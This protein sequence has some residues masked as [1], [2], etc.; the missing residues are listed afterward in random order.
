MP[1]IAS[2]CGGFVL[3]FL[4][5][6]FSVFSEYRITQINLSFSTEDQE[7]ASFKEFINFISICILYLVEF[8]CIS[9]IH[10]NG[11]Y[12]QMSEEDMRSSRTGDIYKPPCT[13]WESNLSP[14]EEQQ[15]LLRA[16]L[17]L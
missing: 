4:K 5:S 7:G 9:L 12:P 16:K 13:G 3:Q 8:Y 6:E 15:V 17:S 1:K 11:W 14:L 10:V 2:R